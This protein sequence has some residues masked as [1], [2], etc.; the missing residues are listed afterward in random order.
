[1]ETDE[2]MSVV[3]ETLRGPCGVREPIT[4]ESRL[5]EDLELDS[6]GM[7]ALAVGL[8]NRF[9]VKLEEDPKNVP[10]TVDELVSLLSR[11]LETAR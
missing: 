3:V 7:L 4:G 9:R 8:E 2:V 10:A 11:R 6:M 1:M 5:Q